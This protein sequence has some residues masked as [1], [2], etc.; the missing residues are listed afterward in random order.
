[1]G[2]FHR[3][4]SEIFQCRTQAQAIARHH[5]GKIVSDLH[6]GLDGLVIGARG[7]CRADCLGGRDR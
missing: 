2:E 1:M 7:K 4:V 3:I 6:L 5:G